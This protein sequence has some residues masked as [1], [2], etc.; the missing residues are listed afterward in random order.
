MQTMHAQF[1]QAKLVRVVESDSTTDEQRSAVFKEAFKN[2]A[3]IKYNL[4]AN[5]I[6]KIVDESKNVDVSDKK[7][8]NEFLQNVD[9]KSIDQIND[10][11]QKINKIGIKKTFTAKCEKCEHE[12]E[13]E[14]DFNPVNFS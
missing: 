5:S 7:Y 4:I 10:Q 13:S 8:I 12:W 14:I 1:D 3:V 9:K 2:I 6:V 11:I